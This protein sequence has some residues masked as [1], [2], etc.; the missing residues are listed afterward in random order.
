MSEKKKIFD[1]LFR[2]HPGNSNIDFHSLLCRLARDCLGKSV[3]EAEEFADANLTKYWNW[4]LQETDNHKQ[5]G[6]I[7]YYESIG[8]NLQTRVLNYACSSLF[9]GDNPEA[10]RSGELGLARSHLLRE[11]DLLTDREYEALACVA[12]DALGSARYH[13]T[14][15]GNEGGVDFF[16]S[17]SLS[18]ASHLFSAPGREIRVVGQCKKYATPAAVGRLEQFIQTMH[19]VRYRSDRVCLPAWF[20]GGRG[21]IIGWVIS[22]S[23][24][25]S[26]ATYEAQKHGI[27][28]SDSLDVAEVVALSE[29]FHSN[30]SPNDRA[31]SLRAACRALL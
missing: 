18:T 29:R 17:L 15:A 2:H 7:P 8:P 22:H 26:G 27:I 14:P 13:L 31:N 9:A 6:L 25:Q 19:N 5:R 21:P 1:G 23:G 28:I 4:L 12:C 16:A 24:F 10:K 30:K 3:F 20:A 11:I